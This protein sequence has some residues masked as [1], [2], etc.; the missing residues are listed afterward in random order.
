MIV[1]T[2]TP[3]ELHLLASAA[4]AAP[5]LHNSQPWR[6]RPTPDLNGLKVYADPARAVPLTDPDGRAMHISIGAALFNLRVAAAHLGR[7]PAVRLLPGGEPY[8]V[9]ILDVRAR[10]A[11]GVARRG[12]VPGDRAAPLQ[13]EQR[14]LCRLRLPHRVAERW[15]L[16]GEGA[17]EV[18][19]NI[20][21]AAMVRAVSQARA[22]RRAPVSSKVGVRPLS[23]MMRP[24]P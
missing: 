14:R 2:P 17:A 11:C 5:S 9:A 3:A 13:P 1:P 16:C 18:R 21:A 10:R 24:G 8:L 12:P 19:W 23:M 22:A 4:G 7:E 20:A 6:F 15:A